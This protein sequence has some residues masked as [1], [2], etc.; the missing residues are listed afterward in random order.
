MWLHKTPNLYYVLWPT[1]TLNVNVKET[2]LSQFLVCWF[3]P[4]VWQNSTL[5][6]IVINS[7]SWR[8]HLMENSL[9]CRCIAI[10]SNCLVSS[11]YSWWWLLSADPSLPQFLCTFAIFLDLRVL[12]CFF[13]I[14]Y[15][16]YRLLSMGS[17]LV[18]L[19]LVLLLLF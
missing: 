9:L 11:Y 5:H 8:S 14:K 17:G 6:T 15:W 4:R 1:W 2:F 3:E 13:S 12:A 19:L 10:A 7:F 16:S 18:L